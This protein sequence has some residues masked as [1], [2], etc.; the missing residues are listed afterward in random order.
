[1]G[2]WHLVKIGAIVGE[3]EERI[4]KRRGASADYSSRLAGFFSSS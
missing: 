4:G 3:G 2:C 1:M